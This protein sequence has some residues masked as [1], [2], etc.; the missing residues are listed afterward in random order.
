M[1]S[2]TSFLNSLTL[3]KLVWSDNPALTIGRLPAARLRLAI[4]PIDEGALHTDSIKTHW[5]LN[6]LIDASQNRKRCLSYSQSGSWCH[7]VHGIL[8]G[9]VLIKTLT[10]TSEW[11]S[12]GFSGAAVFYCSTNRSPPRQS[13]VLESNFMVE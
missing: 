2:E 4:R 11:N 8:E 7:V 5:L 10:V 13:S 9:P 1:G 6:S 12:G 3:K